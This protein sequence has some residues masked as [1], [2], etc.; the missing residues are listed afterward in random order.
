MRLSGLRARLLLLLG[1]AVL[2]AIVLLLTGRS[3]ERR[4]TQRELETQAMN[5]ARLTGQ[6]HAQRVEQAR[7]LLL[8]LATHPAVRGADHDACNRLVRH[9]ASQYE[10]IYATLGRANADGA[11]DC[12]A[13]EGSPAGMT[14]GD[15]DYFQRAKSTGAFVAGDF[16]QGKVR[17]QPTLAFALPLRDERGAVSHVI[18]A[19]VD[20][21]VMSHS[22]ES[23]TRLEGATVALLDRHGA[24]IARS[25]DADQYFGLTPAKAQLAM[26]QQREEMTATF[27]G[28]DGVRRVF[29]ITQVRGRDDTLLGFATV[30]IPETN[31]A[32]LTDRSQTA[33]LTIGALGLGLFFVAWVGSELL[34][35]R[36]IAKLVAA[37]EGLGTGELGLRA[38]P[39]G[40]R[41][42]QQ[43]AA[44]LNQMAGKLQERELHLREGQRLEAVGQLAGGIAHDFN[45]L[46]TVIIGYADALKDSF[47]RG[48]PESAQLAE[49]RAASER[50]ARLTQQLLAFSRRQVLL[51]TPLR[52]NE[53]VGDMASLLRRTTGGDI[54]IDLSLEPSLGLVYADRVQ[55]EQVIL[56]LV[57]NARDAMPKGGNLR[58]ATRNATD[59]EPFVELSVTDSGLGMD[60]ETRSQIFE[61]FFTTKGAQ[62]TGLGLATVYGIVKQS[63]GDIQCESAVGAGTTFRIRLPRFVGDATQPEAERAAQ[64]AGGSETV[65]LVDDDDA[66]RSLLQMVLQRR[67]YRVRATGKATEA[68]QWITDGLRPD[69]IVTDVRMPDMNGVVFARAAKQHDPTLKVILMSGD[70]APS[71]AGQDHLEGATFEQKPVTP[72]ALL[73]AVRARLDET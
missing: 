2:P 7:Q 15:R 21:V 48:T 1:V 58:I 13:L 28:P 65:L 6:A 16:M 22:L 29:A 70:A 69:I 36:P 11:V 33:W 68:L 18:F 41:E 43:L 12:L 45:N 5:L 30:G 17:R 63:G 61:P 67:G 31:I 46:L 38:A 71:L 57:I 51:P 35:R 49:L 40:V 23:A 54:V 27:S 9:L 50:A 8:A 25:A 26:M 37:T 24:L 56:N 34:I 52:L 14:I 19:N 55:M 20:L 64:P 32:A 39:G 60:A 53:V 72:P 59:G 73:R 47:R 10:G 4:A 44:A 3:V 62:G 42:L 66:V